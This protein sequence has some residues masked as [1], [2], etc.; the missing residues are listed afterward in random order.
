MDGFWPTFIRRRP[1]PPPYDEMT[2]G[3]P[4]AD[5]SSPRSVT[6]PLQEDPR[7]P[8]ECLVKRG[9]MVVAGQK[10]GVLGGAPW[11][12]AVHATLSGRVREIDA[13]PTPHGFEV[14]CVVI[15]ADGSNEVRLLNPSPGREGFERFLEAGIP[16]EY[17]KLTS[18]EVSILLVNGTQFEP[19]ITV[20][21][22]IIEE[23]A[24]EIVAGLKAL[25]EAF[26]VPKAMICVEKKMPRLI[27]AL[28]EAGQGW[29]NLT[30]KPVARG[31]PPGT[32]ILLTKEI[33]GRGDHRQVVS[34]IDP[35]VVLA[36]ADAVN[37]G[38]PFLARL[39]TCVGS[40]IPY[41]QNLWVRIGTSFG[42]VITYCGGR[43]ENITQIIMGGP[44]AGIAQASHQVP[45]TRKTTGI[46]AQ[47]ALALGEGHRSRI[48]EEGVCVRCAK[49]V[50][51]C[52]VSILPNLVAGYCQK[53]RFAEALER[54]LLQCVDCGLCSYVCPARIPLAQIF[55][56]AKSRAEISLL[57]EE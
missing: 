2:L 55:K 18:G 54:G 21:H 44:L 53:R 38:I 16:L 8:Y 51:A 46:L 24:R 23:K 52:P 36:A 50:D 11:G 56:E 40:G 39:V 3:V 4:I 26:S 1:T 22:K 9:E 19:L 5:F 14:V 7:T 15:D 10:I 57:G 45:V 42:E 17:E 47:V 31:L 13:C 20:N 28:K 41:P 37:R 49:C 27:G 12:L 43:L 33:L 35:A 6:I 25:C 30:V 29:R 48:Y 32:E 34:V